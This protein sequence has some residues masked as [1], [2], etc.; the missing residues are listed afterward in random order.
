MTELKQITVFTGAGVSAES[1]LQTFRGID[2]LWEG[3]RIED[4]AT[5]EGWEK[6]PELV[7]RFYN[8]RREALREAKPNLA[9]ISV[10]ELE[11][12]A[13]VRVITQNI[14]NL[15]ERAGSS[16]VL[17]LHGEILKAR[18]TADPDLV[19][20]LGDRD[21]HVGDL[22]EQ[23]SQLRPHVVWFGEGLPDFLLAHEFAMQSDAIL[24]IGTSLQV[25]PA[26][27][28][29]YDAPQSCQVYV[30]DPCA[31]ELPTRSNWKLYPMPATVGIEQVIAEM[32]QQLNIG[33]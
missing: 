31:D 5:P 27:R 26:N 21:I 32:K 24:V 15:H 29:V 2:G 6:D 3:H 10:A 18:S 12:F 13:D 1:G 11:R 4:V 16:D 17:H 33:N 30:L 22:C 20:D 14:D 19:Y 7:L 25:F 9:H 23:G 28:L 8:V